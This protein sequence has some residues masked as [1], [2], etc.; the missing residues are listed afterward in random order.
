MT[1]SD[2]LGSRLGRI[3]RVVVV[4]CQ[5]LFRF[6]T[7]ETY[8]GRGLRRLSPSI[9]RLVSAGLYDPRDGSAPAGG[10]EW[11]GLIYLSSSV[12][13]GDFRLCQRPS[14]STDIIF[15]LASVLG[16]RDRYRPFG[17]RPV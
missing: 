13:A 9:I 4:K 3:L 10:G 1:V 17:N 16:T 2:A 11:E 8:L 14:Q 12:Q 7:S 6:R 15:G 5:I